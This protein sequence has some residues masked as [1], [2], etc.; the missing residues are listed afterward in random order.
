PRLAVSAQASGKPFL[1]RCRGAEERLA[2]VGTFAGTALRNGDADPARRFPHRA[3]IVES[4]PLH[5]VGENVSRLVTHIAVEHSL[6]GN[7]GE[8]AVAAAVER[9]GPA[10]VRAGALERHRLADQ[11]HQVSG[12]AYLLDQLVG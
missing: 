3:G 5:Q 8:V 10:P 4:L 6:A 9:A 7:H 2:R 1:R 11:L 12:I